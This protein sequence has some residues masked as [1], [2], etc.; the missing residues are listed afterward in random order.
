VKARRTPSVPLYAVS[1]CLSVCWEF[2]VAHSKKN[3]KKKIKNFNTHTQTHW[4]THTHSK[5]L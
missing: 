5:V 3:T 4:H 2:Y 1:V